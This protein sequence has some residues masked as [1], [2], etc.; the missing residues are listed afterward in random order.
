[1]AKAGVPGRRKPALAWNIHHSVGELSR[2]K[3]MTRI[4]IRLGAKLSGGPDAIIYVSEIS[5]RQHVALGYRDERGYTIANGVDTDV[6]MPSAE[7]RGGLLKELGIAGEPLLIGHFARYHPLKDH[8]NFLRAAA[9]L[10]AKYKQVYFIMAG[11]DVDDRNPEL[12]GLRREL[13][14]GGRVRLLGMRRDIEKLLPSLDVFGL[15]SSSEAMPLTLLEA[16]SC[17]VPCV[18]TDVGDA[19]L[20]VGSAGLVV[21]PRD[22]EALAGALGRLVGEGAEKRAAMGAEARERVIAGYSLKRVLRQYED[23]YR[24]LMGA[25]GGK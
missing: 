5:R 19:A 6:Y 13:G 21:P 20:L 11:K 9:R 4:L 16:M 18:T 25:T 22:A 1:Q 15:S 10:C 2:E 14:I 24:K 7:G 17:G 3:G 23:L 8:T 12:A